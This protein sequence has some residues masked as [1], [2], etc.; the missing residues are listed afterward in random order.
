MFPA[1]ESPLKRFPSA[2]TRRIN[3]AATLACTSRFTF[4]RNG[5]RCTHVECERYQRI[6]LA[7]GQGN[8]DQPQHDTFGHLDIWAHWILGVNGQLK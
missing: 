3:C 5:D 1:N 8:V 6:A 2:H 7:V 4:R